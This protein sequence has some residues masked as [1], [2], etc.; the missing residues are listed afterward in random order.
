MSHEVAIV[1]GVRTAFGRGVKGTLK[2]TRPDT[3]AV[4]VIKTALERSHIP[5][6]EVEDVVLGCAFPEGE[7][8]MNVARTAALAAGAPVE[9]AGM[10]INRFCSSG[11]QSISILADRIA[12]GAIDV[13]VAGV[14]RVDVDGADG[15][16]SPVAERRHRRGAPRDL[17]AHGRD[18]RRTSRAASTSRAP[19]KTP[20]PTSRI[21]G[22]SRRKKPGA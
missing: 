8:G 5:A 16:R 20:S 14:D 10:T 18:R 15:R 6:S 19:I 12:V 22:R 2:D 9:S 4:Q 11:V 1:A 7:Q 21:S 3:L 13:A 17:H